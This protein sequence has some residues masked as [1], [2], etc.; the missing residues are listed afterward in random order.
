[1]CLWGK[2]ILNRFNDFHETCCELYTVGGCFNAIIFFF[3]LMRSAT[4]WTRRF[5]RLVRH[6]RHRLLDADIIYGNKMRNV[7]IVFGLIAVT[8]EPLELGT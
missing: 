7:S 4:R 1:M 3:Y 6:E 5:V 2:G 8:S